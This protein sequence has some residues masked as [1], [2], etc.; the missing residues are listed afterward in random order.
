M[1]R[2]SGVVAPLGAYELGC[3]ECEARVD[4]T[5]GWVDRKPDLSGQPF[6]PRANL[7]PGLRRNR[8]GCPFGRRLWM[9]LEGKP[10]QVS[11]EFPPRL[12]GP[13]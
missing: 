8:L 9:K 13:N 2:T 11:L 3:F 7:W 5:F 6:E 10:T 1:E 4:V 12:F